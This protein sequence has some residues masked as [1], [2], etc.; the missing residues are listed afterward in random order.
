[1]KV[2]VDTSVWVGHFRQR[3]EQLVALLQA[4]LVACHPY[5][6]VEVACG[7]P[8]RRREIIDM[9]GELESVP[10]ATPEELLSL[11]QRRALFGR[12]CGFVD[13]SL[14]AS[15]LLS[16]KTLLWTLDKRLDAIAAELGRAWRP[17]LAS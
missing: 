11:L 12:G 13:V 2:L 16:D 5:V 10:V 3:D 17:S 14:L 8:P 9:L 6:I 1:V 7:T 4:G 15:T